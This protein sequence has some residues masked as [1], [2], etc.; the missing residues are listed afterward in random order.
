M[1]V[2]TFLRK[3]FWIILAL[4]ACWILWKRLYKRKGLK[5]YE[6]TKKFFLKKIEQAD[7]EY[8]RL[9]HGKKTKNDFK[10]YRKSDRI[11]FVRDHL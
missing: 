3:W 9:E 11:K 6:E 2:L 10:G 7:K 8:W 5:Q 4:V 1:K